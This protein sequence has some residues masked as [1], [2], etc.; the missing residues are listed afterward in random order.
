MAQPDPSIRFAYPVLSLSK[1]QGERG[2]ASTRSVRT[3]IKTSSGRSNS[4]LIRYK[5]N[6]C[7]RT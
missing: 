7:L 6:S 2:R 5:N 1:G 4:H 3:E